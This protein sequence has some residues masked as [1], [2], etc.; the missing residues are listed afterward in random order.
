MTII[1]LLGT[2]Y[3]G[4]KYKDSKIEYIDKVYVDTVYVKL[5]ARIDTVIIDNYHTIID[6]VYLDS[7]YTKVDTI[8]IKEGMDIIASIDTTL[9]SDDNIVENRLNI[10]Y[11]YRMREFGISSKYFVT[12]PEN[13]VQKQCYKPSS[14]IIGNIGLLGNESSV[15][16]VFGLQYG[17]KHNVMYNVGYTTENR[18]LIGF[19]YMFDCELPRP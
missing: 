15:E 8:I 5:P 13:G 10:K 1:L 19:G 17:S 11:S 14:K 2:F 6:T 4:Y 7:I 18:F 16:G 9:Y 12:F 3:A